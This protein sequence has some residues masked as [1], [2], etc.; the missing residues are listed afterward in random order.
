LKVLALYCEENFPEWAESLA[1]REFRKL[2]SV[3]NKDVMVR[4]Q[5]V[6][7]KE[8]KDARSR[9]RVDEEAKLL[10]QYQQLLKLSKMAGN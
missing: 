5:F 1:V 7:V 9:G 2:V 6:I 3:A 4:K 8:L 10:H